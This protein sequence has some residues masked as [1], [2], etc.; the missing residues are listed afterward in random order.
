MNANMKLA[1]VM[2]NAGPFFG[3]TGGVAALAAIPNVEAKLFTC[4]V[5]FSVAV[6]SAMRKYLFAAPVADEPGDYPFA[7][8]TTNPWE[9]D[10]GPQGL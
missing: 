1:G 2:T 10:G 6:G 5:M 3:V 9:R 7:A 4:A 8:T